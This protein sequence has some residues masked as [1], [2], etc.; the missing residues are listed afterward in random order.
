MYAEPKEF[1]LIGHPDALAI[2]RRIR[3][4]GYQV[5][6]NRLTAEQFEIRADDSRTGERHLATAAGVGH[7]AEYACACSLADMIACELEG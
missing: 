2:I 6:A 3:A 1:A 5:R 4:L 7:D